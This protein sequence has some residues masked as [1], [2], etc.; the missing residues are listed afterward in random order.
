MRQNVLSDVPP[1]N[2]MAM[3]EAMREYGVYPMR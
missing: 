1:Q 2:F 3:W